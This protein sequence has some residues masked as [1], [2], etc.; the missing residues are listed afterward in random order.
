MRLIGSVVAVL[1]VVALVVWLALSEDSPPASSTSTISMASTGQTDLVVATTTSS[2][3]PTTTA[4]TVTTTTTAAP[5][6]TSSTAPAV[7]TR[8]EETDSRLIYAGDWSTSVDSSASEGEFVF[9]NSDG[10]SVTVA[11]EGTYLAWMVKKSP[12]YGKATVTLDGRSL[13]TVDLYASTAGWQLKVW[14]TGSLRPG[15]HTLTITWT[16]T[17]NSAASDTNIG[18]DAFDVVGVLVPVAE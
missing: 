16:G 18:V 4:E 5:T 7:L 3:A 13:G 8:F 9:A 14:G 1:V 2:V 15:R 11:F 12:A 17:R 10:A 6:T